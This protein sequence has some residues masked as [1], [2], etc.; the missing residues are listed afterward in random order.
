MQ[1]QTTNLLIETEDFRVGYETGLAGGMC[2]DGTQRFQLD[3]SVTA[4]LVVEI[5]RNLTET[6]VEGWLS[7]SLLRRDAGMIAGWILKPGAG[8]DR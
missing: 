5:I 4:E 6:A 8:I 2:I 7:E 1:V 3:Q